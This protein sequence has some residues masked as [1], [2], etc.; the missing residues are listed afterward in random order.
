M[1]AL[2]TY[3]SIPFFGDAAKKIQ[4]ACYLIFFVEKKA[5]KFGRYTAPLR[6]VNVA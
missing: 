1:N 4:L 3:V 2:K 6:A 5:C